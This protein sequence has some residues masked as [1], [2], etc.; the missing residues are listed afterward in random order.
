[1]RILRKIT[2][3]SGPQVLAG[4]T[5]VSLALSCSSAMSRKYRLTFCRK[6]MCNALKT[7]LSG[8]YLVLLMVL[9]GM[10]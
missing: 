2:R 4:L 9:S 8:V 6:Q 10:P 5:G 3:K 1:L 7:K